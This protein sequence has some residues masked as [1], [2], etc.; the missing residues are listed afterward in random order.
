MDLKYTIIEPSTAKIVE[1]YF[2]LRWEVLRKPWNKPIES[3]KFKLEENCIHACA[4]TNSNEIIG[5]GRLLK[6]DET[7]F[8]IRSMAVKPKYNTKGIG[9]SIIAY[10]EEK[11]KQQGGQKIILHARENA[12]NFYKKQG[13]ILKE[14]THLLFGEIQHYLMEKEM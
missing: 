6:V 13:Y 7:T 1:G 10:L 9:K 14:K 12:I 5:T 4:I 8:Q 2:F 3:D 11:A